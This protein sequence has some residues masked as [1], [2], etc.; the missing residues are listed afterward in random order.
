MTDQSSIQRGSAWEHNNLK[1]SNYAFERYMT[2]K[3]Y[4]NLTDSQ[5][6]ST[7]RPSSVASGFRR[8]TLNPAINLNRLRERIAATEA[9]NARYTT[10]QRDWLRLSLEKVGGHLWKYKFNYAIKFVFLFK[11][12]SEIRHF[13]HLRAT[14]VMKGQTEMDHVSSILFWGAISSAS[15]FLI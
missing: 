4:K 8:E 7:S 10:A 6:A 2:A 13:R 9:I 14:T 3:Y 1:G 11:V 5:Y 15:L 12:M